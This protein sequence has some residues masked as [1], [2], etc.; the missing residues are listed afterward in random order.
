MGK[1]MDMVNS[2]GQMDLFMRVNGRM[3]NLGEM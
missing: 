3:I 1:G 2:N